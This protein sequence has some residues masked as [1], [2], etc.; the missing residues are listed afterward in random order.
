MNTRNSS[1]HK[2]ELLAL[3]VF[4]LA[5]RFLPVIGHPH[6]PCGDGGSSGGAEIAVEFSP[7]EY[8]V[9]PE[10]KVVVLNASIS[11]IRGNVS[12]SASSDDPSSFF[13]LFNDTVIIDPDDDNVTF[14]IPLEGRKLSVSTLR[15]TVTHSYLGDVDVAGDV[16]FSG[17]G[18]VAETDPASFK[19]TT[20]FTYVVKVSRKRSLLEMVFTYAML[21]WLVISYVSMGA[22]MDLPAIWKKLRRPYGVLVGISCQFI[23][24]PLIAFGLAHVPGIP[25]EAAIGL[26]IIGSC[27]GGWLSNVFS[28]LMD[29]D[30]V[31]SMTMTF[32][33]S[34]MAL[35]MMPLNMLIYG[36]QI[37]EGNSSLK[38]PY[39]DIA[40]QLGLMLIPVAVGIYIT[41]KFEKASKILLKCLKP[42]ATGLIVIALAIGIP[43]QLY[44]FDAPW[45]IYL[46]CFALPFC[47]GG[48]GFIISKVLRRPKREAYT[49]SF[50]TGVQNSLLAVTVAKLSYPLPEAD[51]IARIP[52][53]V[54]I[55]QLIEG[56]VM[57]VT[58]VIVR[59][60]LIR[61][62]KMERPDSGDYRQCDVEAAVDAD[63]D[64]DKGVEV[65]TDDG[66]EKR[67]LT[68]VDT[69]CDL[70]LKMGDCG[71]NGHIAARDEKK[72]DMKN[73]LN[74]NDDVISVHADGESDSSSECK[75]GYA[76]IANEESD[77]ADKSSLDDADLVGS[78]AGSTP[79]DNRNNNSAMIQRNGK[80]IAATATAAETTSGSAD[81]DPKCT[82]SASSPERE[83]SI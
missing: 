10:G 29:V 57:I 17:D 34:F 20:E 14:D 69:E 40:M 3:V 83:T 13:S 26:L 67:A 61:M 24:M 49:I 71:K 50:E 82:T 46:I 15:L 68:E 33:S 54:A 64:D 75:P 45:R 23:I 47:G 42:M 9:A 53:L 32:C 21:V 37:T 39:K 11:G 62:G 43:S 27:P 28:L 30:F 55:L 59:N 56:S 12:V 48:L 6:P 80:E 2:Q 72:D 81:E 31:L 4:T 5:A 25:N 22:K 38:T 66:E 60:V 79:N 19:E 16:D 74:D 41:Q 78:D 77:D 52:F 51:I 44:I 36:S 7:E 1:S 58:Y 35:G 65:D 70:I 18:G 8:I 76:K 63:G 73:D